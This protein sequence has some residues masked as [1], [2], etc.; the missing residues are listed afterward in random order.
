MNITY[1]E[2]TKF[3]TD[4]YNLWHS[5]VNIYWDMRLQKHMTLKSTKF[6]K[7][8]NKF[9]ILSRNYKQWIEWEAISLLQIKLVQ[10]FVMG[11]HLVV[12]SD[13]V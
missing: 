6:L 8:P 1:I 3:S 2:S 4:Q 5:R 13:T 12:A 10:H 7:Q 11:K 9:G